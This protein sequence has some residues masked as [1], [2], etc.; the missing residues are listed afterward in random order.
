MPEISQ[1]KT[2][3]IFLFH[4]IETKVLLFEDLDWLKFLH[5]H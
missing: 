2:R 3:I 5:N 4:L 1:S